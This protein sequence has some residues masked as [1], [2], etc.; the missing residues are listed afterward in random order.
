MIASAKTEMPKVTTGKASV[1]VGAALIKKDGQI[2]TFDDVGGKNNSNSQGAE[3]N[4]SLS[5][6]CPD[7]K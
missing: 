1:E 6:Q 7:T 2:T 3:C 4:V 5:E